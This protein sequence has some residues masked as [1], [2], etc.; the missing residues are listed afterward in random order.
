M[1]RPIEGQDAPFDRTA[2]N[3]AMRVMGRA[4]RA[5]GTEAGIAKGPY[6]G[7]RSLH[8]PVAR[9]RIRLR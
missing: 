3:L 8:E 6:A 2:G 7:V 9:M 1:S 4:S 5:G